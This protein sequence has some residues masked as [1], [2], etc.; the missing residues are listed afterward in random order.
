MPS[1]ASNG[2]TPSQC[3]KSVSVKCGNKTAEFFP[4]KLKKSGKS[5]SKCIKYMGK[6]LN[7]SE[8]ESMAGMQHTRKWKQSIKCKGKPLGEW[9]TEHGQEMCLESSQSCAHQPEYDVDKEPQLA[10]TSTCPNIVFNCDNHELDNGII[11]IRDNAGN[12]HSPQCD[13]Q[14]SPNITDTSALET[15]LSRLLKDLELK[16]TSSFREL[17]TQ[18]M[19]SFRSQS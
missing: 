9:L 5:V 15:D 19:E 16:L 18:A 14:V 17:I 11:S 1:V 4:S 13:T 2:K 8:F 7:P 12:P 10:D 3:E 6:W